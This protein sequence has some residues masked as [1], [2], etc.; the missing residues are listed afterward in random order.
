MEVILFFIYIWIEISLIWDEIL[1]YLFVKK[2]INLLISRKI[3][4]HNLYDI[5]RYSFSF[6]LSFLSIIKHVLRF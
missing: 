3:L 2:K 4:I 1:K 6:F 5:Q